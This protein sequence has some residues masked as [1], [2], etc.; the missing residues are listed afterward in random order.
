M[1]LQLTSCWI[2]VPAFKI[3]SFE[4]NHLPLIKA[5]A[6]VFVIISTG[7]ASLGE[8]EKAVSTAREAA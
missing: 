8:L 1:S 5:A 6:T 4:N 3:A 7:M 2:R